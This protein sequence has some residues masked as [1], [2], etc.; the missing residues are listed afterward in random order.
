MTKEEIEVMVKY[1]NANLEYG[2]EGMK[3]LG[4][5]L[6]FG[7]YSKKP[8]SEFINEL[9]DKYN[10]VF[11][12]G[13]KDWMDPKNVIGMMEFFP[14]SHKCEEIQIVADCGHQMPLEN[15]AGTAAKIREF[16]EIFKAKNENPQE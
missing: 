14:D 9:V 12:Y 4:F 13:D 11:M 5:F 1:Y 2:D 16:H 10:Y 6:N 7:R 8:Y 15:P 3:V